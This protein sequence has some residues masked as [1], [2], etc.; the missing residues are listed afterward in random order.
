MVSPFFSSPRVR[1]VPGRGATC[2]R[3]EHSPIDPPSGRS[4]LTRQWSVLAPRTLTLR[5]RLHGDK[6]PGVISLSMG[7]TSPSTP[8]LFNQEETLLRS[9][10]FFL[11]RTWA[12]DPALNLFS[13]QLERR[14]PPSFPDIRLEAY[15]LGCFHACT[16]RK[17]SP[18]PPGGRI[19]CPPPA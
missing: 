9:F 16:L 12:S 7:V 17:P 1:L 19:G 5:A 18:N 15:I 11:R 4:F 13:L 14:L 6:G 3:R 2:S 8:S 10:S